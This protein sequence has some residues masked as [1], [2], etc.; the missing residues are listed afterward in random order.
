[1]II[2]QC[3]TNICVISLFR[4]LSADGMPIYEGDTRIWQHYKVKLEREAMI[5]LQPKNNP[6][7]LIREYFPSIEIVDG[8]VLDGA[9]LFSARLY[10]HTYIPTCSFT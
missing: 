4:C 9:A 3:T 1:M 2:E 6:M 10:I 5:Q 8:P 7:M